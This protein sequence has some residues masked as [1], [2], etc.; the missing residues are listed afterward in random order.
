MSVALIDLGL[1]R[2][3][4]WS[5]GL[6]ILWLVVVLVRDE[7]TLHLAPLIVAGAPPVLNAF[8]GSTTTDGRSA[9]LA[10]AAGFGIA[11]A[12]ALVLILTG[13]LDGPAI[14]PF[15][16][17]LAETIIL[18]IVGAAAGLLIGIARNRR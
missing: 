5:I 4:G 3:V 1:R 8:D 13:N 2:A 12:G 14:E 18:A 16:S 9:V 10:A 15:G 6:G 7:T 17:V 11:M